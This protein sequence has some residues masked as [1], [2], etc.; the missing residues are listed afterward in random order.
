MADILRLLNGSDTPEKD[1]KAFLKAQTIFCL[2]GATDG[3]AK[4]FSI[5]LGPGGRFH[6]TP[7]YDV[8]TAQP[9]LDARQIE[10]KQMKLAMFV[11]DSRH[12]LI[13]HIRGRH[14]VQI[15]ERAGLPGAMARSVLNEIIQG[16][17][18]ALKQ[19]ESELPPDFPEEIHTSVK[20]GFLSRLA[21]FSEASF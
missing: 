16:A 12:Y 21:N 9:S 10:R 5:F 4:N 11:G 7:F 8:L 20:A 19:V 13:S 3:H 2:I 15:A 14:F 17:D 1:Q 6:L 18:Q